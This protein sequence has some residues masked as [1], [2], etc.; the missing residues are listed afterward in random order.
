MQEVRL[1]RGGDLSALA[2]APP[3]LTRLTFD[4]SKLVYTGESFG[5]IMGATVLAVDP[6]LEAGVIDVGGGGILTDLAPNSPDFAT[7]LGPFIASAF[8]TDVDVRIPTSQPVR[9]QMSL[10]ML[11]R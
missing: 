1:A 5:S 9:A 6:M 11:Q 2:T 10:N 7:L 4:G 8:D 3:A